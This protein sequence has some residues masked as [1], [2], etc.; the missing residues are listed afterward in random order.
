MRSFNRLFRFITEVET[1]FCCCQVYHR[2]T[3]SCVGIF[4]PE[5]IAKERLPAQWGNRRYSFYDGLFFVS[6][7]GGRG[8][9]LSAGRSAFRGVRPLRPWWG[10]GSAGPEN[11]PVD[12]LKMDNGS[13]AVSGGRR[14][15]PQ[16]C[17]GAV[18]PPSA[19]SRVLRVL[20]PSLLSLRPSPAGQHLSGGSGCVSVAACRGRKK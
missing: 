5:H 4:V 14:M 15:W 11:V 18:V 9:A 3:I 19:A 20:H 13:L 2:T 7:S 10:R 1:L 16:A 17:G 6:V 8:L 12:N